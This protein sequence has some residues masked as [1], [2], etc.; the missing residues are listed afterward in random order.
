[1]ENDWIGYAICALIIVSGCMIHGL[2]P[3]SSRSAPKEHKSKLV[4][5]DEKS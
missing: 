1:M 5:V 2:I 4:Q 3:G